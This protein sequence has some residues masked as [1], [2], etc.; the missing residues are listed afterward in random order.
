MAL[1]RMLIVVPIFLVF[2]LQYFFFF[3]GQF[4]FL[5]CELPLLL[6]DGPLFDDLVAGPDVD[7][8]E[9]QGVPDEAL[10]DLAVERGVGG[11]AWSVVDLQDIGLALVIKHDIEPK[12]F[13]AHIIKVVVRLAGP[14]VVGEYGLSRNEGLD[15]HVFDLPPDGLSVDVLCYT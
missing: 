7:V 8:H 3:V 13:E 5:A 4:D 1:I 11:E 6:N 12:D 2:F 9:D 10:F 14:D 15:D